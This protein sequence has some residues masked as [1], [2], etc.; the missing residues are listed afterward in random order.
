MSKSGINKRLSTRYDFTIN[1]VY[2]RYFL[3]LSI[4]GMAASGDPSPA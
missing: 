4:A 2:T 1:V 3:F